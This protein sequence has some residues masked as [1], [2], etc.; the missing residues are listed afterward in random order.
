MEMIA[1]EIEFLDHSSFLIK[2]SIGKRIL[3]DPCPCSK[4]N[5]LDDISLI[6]IS[7]N[8]IDHNYVPDSLKGCECIQSCGDFTV[9]N[10]LIKGIPSFHDE[11]NGEKR[12]E[13]IIYTYTIDNLKLCHLGDLGHNLTPIQLKELKDIDILFI[14]I[15]G[16]FTLDGKQASSLCN[17]LKPKVV[18]PMHYTKSLYDLTL[19]SIDQFI[20]SMK[21][22]EVFSNP[23][24]VEIKSSY[25]NKVVIL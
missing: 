25:N 24:L 16:N 6:T 20:F 13:N 21:N 14:P 9:E 23:W 15:G 18:I 3:I 17:V 7:H 12:G 10:I 4:I 8:H 22:G 2:S 1:L 11:L 19:D 5:E